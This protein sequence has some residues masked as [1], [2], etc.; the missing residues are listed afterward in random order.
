MI[1]DASLVLG[2]A[3]GA[4][5]GAAQSPKGE[6]AEGAGYGAGIGL[7]TELGAGVGGTAGLLAGG[8]I[9]GVLGTVLG[10]ILANRASPDDQLTAGIAGGTLG[11]GIGGAIGG[12]AG[13]GLGGYGGYRLSKGM[14]KRIAG[15]DK[16]PWKRTGDLT[17]PT[18]ETE[19]ESAYQYGFVQKCAELGIDPAA[20]VKAAQ[21]PEEEEEKKRKRSK[22]GAITLGTLAALAAGGG[23]A[24]YYLHKNPQLRQRLALSLAEGRKGFASGKGMDR[25][26][27]GWGRAKEQFQLTP[28][29]QSQRGTMRREG[30][31]LQERVG[32]IQRAAKKPID[33][34]RRTVMAPVRG[35]QRTIEDWKDL[36]R[37][38]TEGQQ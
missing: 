35:A 34:I 9:G 1:K 26:R 29:Q 5:I 22:R 31:K 3:I 37:G 28:R 24:A 8:G 25:F 4:G 30:A 14:A 10:R 16:L 33:I 32:A 19:K 15:K 2:P 17:E 23:A 11:T 38:Y 20:L 6:K 27:K 36:F 12:L 21:T 7:G 18:S 13:A